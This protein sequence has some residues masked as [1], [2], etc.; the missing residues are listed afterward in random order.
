MET[1]QCSRCDVRKVIGEFRVRPSGGLHSRCRA[2]VARYQHDWYVANREAVI[3][4]AR[5]RGEAAVAA[6]RVRVY[7][8]LSKHPCVDCG[9]S[10][11][12]VLEFDHVGTKR[13]DISLMT[14]AGYA[15]TTIQ[16]EIARCLVRCGS[17]H[18]R[19][20]AR[21]QGI[22]EFKRS[23]GPIRVGTTTYRGRPVLP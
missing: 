21:E 5:A 16:E 3:A 9:E 7:T 22:Y 2:C 23:F 6:N 20:T 17:C 12:A 14:R 19:K 1:K 13:G 15:W 10:D 18:R 4:R 11:P 8:Y